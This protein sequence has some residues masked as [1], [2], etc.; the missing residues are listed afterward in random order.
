MLKIAQER[1]ILLQK[2]QH[3]IE[4]KLTL[5]LDGLAAETFWFVLHVNK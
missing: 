2:K 4:E 5:K 3:K 1:A